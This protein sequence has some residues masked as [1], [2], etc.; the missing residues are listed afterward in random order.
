MIRTMDDILIKQ[1]TQMKQRSSHK[2]GPPPKL[3]PELEEPLKTILQK[4][5]KPLTTDNIP[6]S[7]QLTH[8]NSFR[9]DQ[10]TYNGAFSCKEIMIPGS[11]NISQ[12]SLIICQPTAITKASGVIY[13]I[14]GGGMVAGNNRSGEL[15][16]DLKRAKQLNLAIVAINYRLAPEYPYPIP[17]EDC[18]TGLVW[19]EKN[20][21]SLN[22]CKKIILSGNSAGGGLAACV[23]LLAR[24]RNGP[25]LSG[26]MLQCPMLDDRCNTVSAKQMYDV[27]VWDT[28]S[29]KTGWTALL[30]S[31]RATNNIS[32]Y[33]AAS[34]AKDLSNLPPTFIDV[35]SV[36]SLRD[37][38]ILFANHIW[39]HGGY[40]ELHVWGGAFHSFDQWVPD[41]IISQTANQARIDW[42]KRI[43]KQSS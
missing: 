26:Q 34:R 18:Y 16:C 31:Q 32:A 10:L 19:L 38:A 40:A 24:D 30:G 39:Q 33:A 23:S 22:T 25:K 43:L 20:L 13:H 42:L 11:D 9:N 5:P 2:I 8:K 7:R 28:I 6:L 41:A 21:Q 17:V 12:L 14:H 35:G 29:N 37:E 15:A 4:L 36:E 3:E 27:G 1:H